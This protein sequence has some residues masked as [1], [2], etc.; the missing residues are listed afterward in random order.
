MRY[1]RSPEQNVQIAQAPGALFDVRLLHADRAPEFGVARLALLHQLTKQSRLL[2]FKD[3]F[4]E[5]VC[6][7]LEQLRF[8]PQQPRVDHRVARND[9]LPGHRYAVAEAAHAVPDVET[10]IPEQ[11]ENRF[12][13]I[14]GERGVL[15]ILVQEHNV[16]VRMRREFAPPVPADGD[17]RELPAVRDVAEFVAEFLFDSRAGD[18]LDQQVDNQTPRLNY[19]LSAYPEPVPQAQSLCLYFQE[20]FERDETLRRIR[21][22]L[23]LT[24]LFARVT[25]NCIQINLHL[26]CAAHAEV[27]QAGRQRRKI[28]GWPPQGLCLLAFAAFRFFRRPVPKTGRARQKCSS[29]RANSH[30]CNTPA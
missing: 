6:K 17:D 30:F 2:F 14:R 27:E 22:I 13:Q 29:C 5:P 12:A 10:Y 9:V 19:L 25:L 24:Q 11:I 21:L 1:A 4:F 26:I 16:D 20:F 3:L 18:A 15:A 28:A 8:A 7:L 23:D